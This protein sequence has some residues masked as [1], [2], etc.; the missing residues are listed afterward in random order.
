MGSVGVYLTYPVSG[1][2][3]LG[4]VQLCLLVVH[5]DGLEAGQQL[6]LPFQIQH[7]GA[8]TLQPTTQLLYTVT[9]IFITWVYLSPLSIPCILPHN[10][11]ILISIEYTLY[12][13]TLLVSVRNLNQNV[14]VK[15]FV[16]KYS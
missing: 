15:N 14:A 13:A 3:D 11:G 10:L 4:L 2:V 1:G 6:V 8:V 12:I 16:K 9:F 7:Q 5:L